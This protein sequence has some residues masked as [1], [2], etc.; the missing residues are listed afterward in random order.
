MGIDELKRF[1]L[2][3]SFM[4]L[5]LEVERLRILKNKIREE[6]DNLDLKRI[7][8]AELGVIGEFEIH[9]VYDYNHAELNTL[10]HNVGVLP[11]VTMIKSDDLSEEEVGK[12][13]HIPYQRKRYLRFTPYSS[14]IQQENVSLFKISLEEVSLLDK[15]AMWKE[16]HIK[17]ERL[18]TIW[19]REKLRA[20]GSPDLKSAKKISFEGG[21][22]SVLESPKKYRTDLVLKHF[23]EKTILTFVRVNLDKMD[24]IRVRGFLKKD[25]LDGVRR[26][27]NLQ[28]R[29][30]L[31][32]MQ[33]AKVK[34]DVWYSKLEK[35][36]LLSQEY[37]Q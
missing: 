23:D 1:I 10:L 9:K 21:V 2:D 30:I 7:V 24:E 14:Y 18:N 22:F 4:E 20:L 26:V 19:E 31:M 33:K 37:T 36:S 6:Q 29:Y 35:L 17:I 25:E 12:V 13:A 34:K 15:V 8:W 5:K 16:S 11:L 28:R 27:V 32:T 3:G